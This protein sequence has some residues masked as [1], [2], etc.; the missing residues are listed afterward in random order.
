MALASLVAGSSGCDRAPE[1]EPA[2]PATKPEPKPFAK[3]AGAADPSKGAAPKGEAPKPD[4]PTDAEPKEVAPAPPPATFRSDETKFPVDTA[5]FRVADG[6]GEPIRGIDLRDAGAIAKR[7]GATAKTRAALLHFS[8][9]GKPSF[10][11]SAD[12]FPHV[13]V[14]LTGPAVETMDG[15]SVGMTYAQLLAKVPTAN[16]LLEGNADGEFVYCKIGRGMQ[17][18]FASTHPKFETLMDTE[19]VDVR[20]AVGKAKVQA[21]EGWFDDVPAPASAVALPE[22]AERGVLPATLTWR[23]YT[24]CGMNDAP[25]PCEDATAAVVDGVL[26]ESV[27]RERLGGL[28][29]EGLAPGYPMVVHSDELGLSDASKRGVVIVLGLFASETAAKAWR[30]A[31]RPKAE[32]ATLASPK[33]FA[34]RTRRAADTSVVVRIRPGTPVA[35]YADG[36]LEPTT[37]PPSAR[38]P[39]CTIDGGV[40]SVVSMEA[41]DEF[42]Y[43]SAPVTC[44]GGVDAH[45]RWDDTMSMTV[46]GQ[47][48]AGPA[49]WQVVNVECDSPQYARWK[50]SAAGDRT[51]KPTLLPGPDC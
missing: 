26:A 44:P 4:A 46:V 30:D 32:V 12:G 17:A 5:L 18:V 31:E 45:V 3:A 9:A 8:I 1:G 49:H 10:T 33:A 25:T 42:V 29:P 36:E 20:A 16:C 39:L 48:K 23:G 27:A 11:K 21:V 50:L 40:F 6:S 34:E 22:S 19:P 38:T 35:A 28:A 47:A 41:H 15:V 2:K 43:S 13:V 37:E 7:T 51:G 14:T 24:I